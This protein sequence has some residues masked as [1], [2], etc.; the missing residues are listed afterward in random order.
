[1]NRPVQAPSGG[2]SET[3]STIVSIVDAGHSHSFTGTPQYVSLPVTFHGPW[4]EGLEVI[5]ATAKGDAQPKA[6]DGAQLDCPR[7]VRI[8][9][10]LDWVSLDR[11]YVAVRGDVFLG[12]NFAAIIEIPA[13]S[14]PGAVIEFDSAGMNLAYR[15]NT[16]VTSIEWET[17]AGWVSGTFAVQY[18]SRLGIPMPYYWGGTV[19]CVGEV[20]GAI[21]SHLNAQNIGTVYN[22]TGGDGVGPSYK[23]SLDPNGSRTIMAWFTY[24]DPRSGFVS[25]STSG[26]TASAH[27]HSIPR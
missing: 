11:I 15:P 5:S 9:L 4:A 2:A 22:A 3:D 10:S 27:A 8:K 7:C 14:A 12:A 13:N 23:P 21:D 16:R 20:G 1:M 24:Q 25:S 19:T 18:S 17:P 26:I 6:L